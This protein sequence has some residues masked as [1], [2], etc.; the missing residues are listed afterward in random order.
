MPEL[1]PSAP[2]LPPASRRHRP[3]ERQAFDTLFDVK[4][5]DKCSILSKLLLL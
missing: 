5:G 1:P 4:Q 3:N 2:A